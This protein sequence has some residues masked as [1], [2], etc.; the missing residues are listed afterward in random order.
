MEVTVQRFIAPERVR[1]YAPVLC[2]VYLL[3]LDIA[4]QVLAPAYPTGGRPCEQQAQLLRALVVMTLLQEPSITHFVH[5]L[6]AEPIL[7]AACGFQRNRIPGVGTFY[8]FQHRLW[9]AAQGP[10][11]LRPLRRRKK[12]KKRKG[13]K[14][15]ERRPG[16]VKR[17]VTQLKAGRR[18]TRRPERF[19]QQLFAAV[20]VLPSAQLGL[21]GNPER[22]ALALDGAPLETGAAPHGRKTCNCTHQQCECSRRYSDPE[23][24]WGWDSYHER[25]FYGHTLYHVTAAH[26]PYDL[27]VLVRLT[28]ASRHDSVTGTVALAETR[29]LYP[30]LPWRQVLADAAHDAAAFYHLCYN[31]QLQPFIAKNPRRQGQSDQPPLAG[32]TPEGRPICPTGQTMIRDGYDYQRGRIKWRC[33]K[34]TKRHNSQPP[35]CACSDSPYGRVVYTYPER[36][37]PPVPRDSKQWRKIYKRRTAV[38]RSLKRSLVD[39]ELERSRVRG[40]CHWTWR[41][42]LSALAQHLD[43]WMDVLQ[44]DVQELL[45]VA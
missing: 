41:A 20:A 29:D 35:P 26:S 44:P 6:R 8:D 27:P 34:Y 38:E 36:Q 9:A 12:R 45:S 30:H 13:E 31:W 10:R 15:R 28:Q 39:Y 7:A 22:L 33:P 1:Y 23:A 3:N 18:F 14:L 24:N 32:C 4:Q 43:A 11:N 40:K 21:L 5:K 19:L 2:R 42:T 25:W 37:G 16:T 17:F